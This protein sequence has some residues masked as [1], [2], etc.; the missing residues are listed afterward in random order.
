MGLIGPNGSGKSTSIRILM[1]LVHQDRGTVHVLDQPM[2]SAQV[3]AKKQI[4]FVSEDMHLYKKAT[5]K[6]HM[7]FIRNIYPDWDDIY[8]AHL[9]KQFDLNRSAWVATVLFTPGP[10][11]SSP[12]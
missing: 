8:A 10:F 3:T 6:W 1:G 9:L 12:S 2:P 4:G 11:C 5:I 7:N